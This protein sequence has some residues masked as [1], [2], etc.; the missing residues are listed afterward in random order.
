MVELAALEKRCAARYQG[1]ESLSLRHKNITTILVVIFL[2]GTKAV[3][4][5]TFAEQKRVR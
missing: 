1:F 4:T 5:R 3:R 2:Y